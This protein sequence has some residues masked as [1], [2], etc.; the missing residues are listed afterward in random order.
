METLGFRGREG[1]IVTT[2]AP[3]SHG[4]CPPP[5]APSAV[6]EAA[7]PFLRSVSAPWLRGR[8]ERCALAC[9]K[10]VLLS[11]VS[12]SR[13]RR[14][15]RPEISAAKAWR[16]ELSRPVVLIWKGVVGERLGDLGLLWRGV[17]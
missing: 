11:L 2:R 12:S 4:G 6:V 9:F 3:L 7:R 16:L 10:M 14:V 8:P 1:L 5:P 17:L 15:L 13:A